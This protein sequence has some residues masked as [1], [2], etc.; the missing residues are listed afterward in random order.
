MVIP[1][2][3]PDL[4][5][6]DAVAIKIYMSEVEIRKYVAAG[7]FDADIAETILN[8]ADTARGELTFDVLARKYQLSGGYIRNACLRA[9]YLAAQEETSLHQHHLERAVTLE[10]AELG[11]LSATGAIA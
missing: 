8:Y 10:L 3:A 1:N 6:A 9:A 2:H 5:T 4:Y 7:L 11:K